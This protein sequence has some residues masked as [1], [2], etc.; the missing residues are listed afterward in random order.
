MNDLDPGI[1]SKTDDDDRSNSV[2]DEVVR[3]VVVLPGESIQE[4]VVSV[5][6]GNESATG[7]GAHCY[8]CHI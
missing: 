5:R 8:M 1:C 3:T 4:A 2:A 6:C 7:C